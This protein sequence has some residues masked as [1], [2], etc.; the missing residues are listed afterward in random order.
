MTP[1]VTFGMYFLRKRMPVYMCLTRFW[2]MLFVGF[3]L[4]SCS[5]IAYFVN[6]TVLTPFMTA[7]YPDGIPKRPKKAMSGSEFIRLTEGKSKEDRE[8]I[9]LREL[10]RGNIPTFLKELQPVYLTLKKG[11][12][13]IHRGTVWVMP[14]YLAI[15][16]DGDF[17]RIPM[18]PLT[19]QRVADYFG[20]SLPTKKLVDEIYRQAEVK[21]APSPLP[22]GDQMV[23]SSYYS[24]HDRIIAKQLKSISPGSLTAGH[25]KDVVLTNRLDSMPRRVA[26]YGWHKAPIKPA[27]D[28][29]PIQ[30][31]SLVHGN[32]YADY[33]HG[34]RLFAKTMIVDGDEIP[35]AEVLQ[36]PELSGLLSDEGIITKTRISTDCP[37]S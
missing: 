7:P 15:G 6:E 13:V 10:R 3:W 24:K 21:L 8:F 33:S 31:L 11:N 20:F 16:R 12:D 19:A 14:D 4:T 37:E 27:E 28:A 1:H 25:K 29:E 35:V 30:S 9:I 2:F 17:V 18:N 32:K 26:I 34:I 5:H 23:D 22:P 36:N